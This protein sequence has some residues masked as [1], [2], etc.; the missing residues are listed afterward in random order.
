MRSC[1][2]Q[3]YLRQPVCDTTCA[4]VSRLDRCHPEAAQTARG[5]T[6]P[7]RQ[8]HQPQATVGGRAPSVS[9]KPI[10][11]IHRRKVPSNDRVARWRTG[12]DARSTDRTRAGPE[13]G[14][15]GRRSLSACRLRPS[16]HK[17]ALPRPSQAS[18]YTCSRTATSRSSV[19]A[20]K[21][22][23]TAIR[24]PFPNSTHNAPRLTPVKGD[25]APLLT[26]ST[27]RIR[28]ATAGGSGRRRLQ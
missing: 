10:A 17:C 2:M 25:G 21:P 4:A 19:V 12:R 8:L 23:A 5:S 18:P 3:E 7:C 6:A 15:T 1:A 26:N 14:H 27:G 16:L 28:L 13:L 9:S 22:C 24:R 20:S 11:P